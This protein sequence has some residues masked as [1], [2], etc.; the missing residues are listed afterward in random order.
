MSCK[1]EPDRPDK[2]SFAHAG[3]DSGLNSR[4]PNA[5]WHKLDTLID[6]I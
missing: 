2:R 5:Y 3:R 1:N 6:L 4:P